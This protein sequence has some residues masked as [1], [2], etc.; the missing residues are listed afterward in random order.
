MGV[1]WMSQD[2]IKIKTSQ[3]SKT[4]SLSPKDRLDMVEAIALM[5]QYV[6]SSCQG[7]AQWIYNPVVINRFNEKELKEF[8]EKFKKFT[9]EFLD[10]DLKATKKLKPLTKEEE[11]KPSTSHY[12]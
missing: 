9:M 5:D 4:K 8:Y 10:F 12:A 11:K 3:L 7:W 2:W 6:L 1:L